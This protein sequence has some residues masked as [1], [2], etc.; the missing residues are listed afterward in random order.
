MR[1]AEIKPEIPASHFPRANTELASQKAEKSL[2]N[3]SRRR[4]SDIS[5]SNTVK[6]TD[7]DEFE[8]DDLE[9]NDFVA[10]GKLNLPLS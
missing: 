6:Y 4:S 1:Y 5:R 9:I 7:V 10:A 8:G 3:S 2:M